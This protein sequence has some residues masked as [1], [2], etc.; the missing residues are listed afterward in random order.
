MSGYAT[1]VIGSAAGIVAVLA[2]LYRLILRP[3]A[4]V[5]REPD[6]DETVILVDGATDMEIAVL[7]SKLETNGIASFA[8]NDIALANLG[9]IPPYGWMLFV[10]YGDV[11]AARRVLRLDDEQA[12]DEEIGIGESN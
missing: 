3:R 2:V 12:I 10:R 9:R 5:E 1:V 11:A 7:R 6:P 8:K 4:G